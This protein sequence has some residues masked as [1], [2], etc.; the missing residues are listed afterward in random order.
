M[1][2]VPTDV[3][4]GSI[5]CHIPRVVVGIDVILVEYLAT[6]NYLVVHK[7]MAGVS[8]QNLVKMYDGFMILND[9]LL[10]VSISPS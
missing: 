2:W 4:L 5:F 7:I 8:L 1:L 6:P 9:W 10:D 3:S